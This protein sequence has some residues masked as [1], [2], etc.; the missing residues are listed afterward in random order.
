M[1]G[2]IQADRIRQS[3]HQERLSVYGDL[4]LSLLGQSTEERQSEAFNVAERIRSRTLL[5]TM[6]ARTDDV[7][8][9]SPQTEAERHLIE[10]RAG[11]R[12]WL[13]WMYSSL[14]DGNEPTDEQLQELRTRERAAIQ[15]D[16]RLATL[17][18]HSGFDVPLARERVQEMMPESDVILSYLKVDDQYTVQI[19]DH[20]QAHG[21]A[22]LAS[23]AEIGDLVARL[24]FQLGRALAHGDRDIS[25]R[26]QA[27]VQRDTDTILIRLYD[28][29]IAPLEPLMRGKNRVIVIPSGD[30]YSV[31]FS[32]LL[33]DG[34]YLVDRFEFSTA[35]GIS[36][37]DGIISGERT[38][39]GPQQ[40]PLIVGVPDE[41]APGLGAE[42]RF[43]GERFPGAT[44]LIGVDATRAAVLANMPGADL[45]HLACHGRF[46]TIHP[47][48]SGLR[49]ADG[50]LTLD[51]LLG[52]R[53]DRPL[54]MLTGCET[55][56]VRVERGDDLAGMMA[57][58][59]GSGAGGLVTSL[60]K[61]HD[62]AATAT[63]AAFYDALA[64]GADPVT[65]LRHSQRTVK[66]QFAH[67]A[68]WA[69]FV[70][71]H[72]HMKGTRA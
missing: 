23:G 17:R 30:L 4:Y 61:T 36:I 29:L 26:R 8:Q 6:N 55:G 10:D 1:R 27:R 59:I 47:T 53:L 62:Q 46:D 45:I 38:M 71:V 57:A 21:V 16:D 64:S 41:A 12:R 49:L 32:A 39:H 31:P 60:W 50:W 14:A 48:A 63:M 44:T 42:A 35:P 24:Q 20:D 13:N 18:P 68:F 70:G 22:N 37:L 2:T 9:R 15:L 52:L 5:D 7:E 28:K 67:P 51:S 11:H 54:V 40:H 19:I 65:A 69:P 3:W 25:P 56:R 66:E 34:T 58:L 72:A 43:V 33:H